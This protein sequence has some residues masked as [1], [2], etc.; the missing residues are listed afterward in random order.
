MAPVEGTA[1]VAPVMD[2]VMGVAV[3]I[4]DTTADVMA[5]VTD[6]ATVTTDI[7]MAGTGMP[8]RGG[9]ERPL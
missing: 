8:P 5:H 7:I 9:L 2:I 4:T 6:I 1:G 3:E